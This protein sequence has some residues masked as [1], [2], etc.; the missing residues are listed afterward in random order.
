MQILPVIHFLDEDTTLKQAE[1]A[2]RC[3]AD[4]VF[5]ICHDG[6]SDDVIPN[7]AAKIKFPDFKVGINLLSKPPNIAF[8]IAEEH[9]LDMLWVDRPGVD[10]DGLDPDGE[11]LVLLSVSNSKIEVFASVAFK[12]QEE[13]KDPKRAAEQARG[14]GW[15]PTTSGSATGQPPS[16]DK[17]R[18]M[19]GAVL[20]NASGITP[21]NIVDYRGLLSH[22]LVATGISK[23][24]YHFD[25]DKLR[26]L[27]K[28]AEIPTWDTVL[29]HLV[30]DGTE[31]HKFISSAI[32][33]A[34]L[35]KEMDLPVCDSIVPL[36][37]DFNW[38][39]SIEWRMGEFCFVIEI[40]NE[41]MFETT[42]FRSG[43]VIEMKDGILFDE[44]RLTLDKIKE[45]RNG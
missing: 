5:L 25:E 11:K 23:D 36:G 30:S 38:A 14:N 2:F 32:K 17:I 15:I 45:H 26:K 28:N 39:I 37:D 9:N 43:Q 33:I 7:I 21:E 4:G 35:C 22:V 20:A 8:E 27:I 41:I 19:S 44:L 13:E 34:E 40:I 31:Y 29:N 10:S 1:L 3:G 6:K 24:E 16:I 18:L 42:T 12:Y